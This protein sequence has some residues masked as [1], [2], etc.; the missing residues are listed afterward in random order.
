MVVKLGLSSK[1]R[2]TNWKCWRR[3]CWGE[4]LDLKQRKQVVDFEN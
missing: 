4:Y 2:N 1:G 3:E